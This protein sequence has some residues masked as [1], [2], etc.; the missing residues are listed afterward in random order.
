[1]RAVTPK[2]KAIKA[3]HPDLPDEDE[4][5]DPLNLDQERLNEEGEG[6][7]RRSESWHAFRTF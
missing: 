2:D 6:K 4:R 3:F 7:Q 1:M 5:F